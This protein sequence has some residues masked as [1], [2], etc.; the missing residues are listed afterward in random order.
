MSFTTGSR[1]EPQRP[2][3]AGALLRAPTLNP[4]ADELCRDP[5]IAAVF[6]QICGGGAGYPPVEI[7]TTIP[8]GVVTEEECKDRENAAYDR[9]RS[10]ERG[11]ILFPAIIGGLASA[12]AGAFV[13]WLI[14]K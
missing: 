1:G 2:I 5:A 14:S 13:G 9:G 12:G 6:P 4:T 11:A 3:G 7:P 10:A 8:T